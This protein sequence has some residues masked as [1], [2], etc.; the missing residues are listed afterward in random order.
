[1]WIGGWGFQGVNILTDLSAAYLSMVNIDRAK[2]Y[3]E[4]AVR[5]DPGNALAREILDIIARLQNKF[6]S[7]NG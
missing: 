5:I 6:K 3:R 4:K 2:E 1:M 7:L